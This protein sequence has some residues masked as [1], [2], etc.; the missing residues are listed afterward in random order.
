[1]RGGL[2][3]VLVVAVG[4]GAWLARGTVPRGATPPVAQVSTTTAPVTRGD[5][6]RRVVV[7]GTVDY[8]GRYP[9]VTHLPAG[10]L[11]ALPNPGTVVRR[12][13]RLFAVAGIEAV[14]LFGSIP[15]YRDFATGMSDG[16]DVRQLEANL[17]ALGADPHHTMRVDNHF[18]ATTAS[19][20]ERWQAA[21]GV[22]AG[23]RTRT[24]PLGR[25]VFLPGPIRVGEIPVSLGGSVT[26]GQ[27]VLSATSTTP[28]VTARVGTD[29]QQLVHVGDTVRVSLPAGEPVPGRVTRV[30]QV[31]ATQ[32]QP[33]SGGPASPTVAVTVAVSLPAPVGGLDQAPAQVQITVEQ[34]HS[35]LMV[36]VTA[37]LSAANGYQLTVVE[38][39][40]RRPLDVQPGLYD[41]AAGT[42]EVTAAGLVEG[43]TVE[44]PAS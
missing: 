26:P 31:P 10:V 44:V 21:A 5:V 25:V 37:L 1:M 32:N 22:P 35:V 41:D 12:G 24:V 3:L 27:P 7:S 17:V 43:M 2:V 42:V 39:G 8:D 36:P 4:Y 28:V 11:T 16:G 20:I 15:A 13:G 30:S 23:Q 19:A 40:I 29:Q 38:D 9:V 33:A 18:S 14:L 6:V 34:H